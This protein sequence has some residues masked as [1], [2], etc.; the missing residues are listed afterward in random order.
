MPIEIF[1]HNTENLVKIMHT[2]NILKYEADDSHEICLEKYN[3]MLHIRHD[4]LQCLIAEQL[5]VVAHLGT[6]MTIANALGI[7]SDDPI[8][9]LTPDIVVVLSNV[10]HLIDP[11]ISV[12][13]LEHFQ[14][15]M[16]KYSKCE[17]ALKLV[18]Y[19]VKVWP[20]CVLPNL[21]NLEQYVPG[22]CNWPP[23][24]M[25]MSTFN[26]YYDMVATACKVLK[27][28]IP[29]ALF[30]M[31]DEV[32]GVAEFST[33][34][35]DPHKY[36][37]IINSTPAG[38]AALNHTYM[39]VN[40]VNE[41]FCELAQDP[42]IVEALSDHPTVSSE[43]RLAFNSIHEPPEQVGS[44]YKPTFHIPYAPNLNIHHKVFKDWEIDQVNT[45]GILKIVS[46]MSG[47]HTLKFVGHIYK[48]LK[49]ALKYQGDM[50]MF[51]T[52]FY[53]GTYLGDKSIKDRYK[54]SKGQLATRPAMI[55]SGLNLSPSRPYISRGRSLNLPAKKEGYPFFKKSGTNYTKHHPEGRI[56]GKA[57]SCP[58]DGGEH[59]AKFIDLVSQ[60]PNHIVGV[61]PI[62]GLPIGDDSPIAMALK[63]DFRAKFTDYYKIVSKTHC[64]NMV[65][66]TRIAAKAMVH[67]NGTNCK[68]D[69]LMFINTGQP[70][71]LHIM[72]G[73]GTDRAHDTGK[74]FFSIIITKDLGW[75]TP[76]F[77]EFKSYYNHTLQAHVVIYGWRR[78]SS[79]RLMFISDNYYSTLSTGFDTYTRRDQ[80]Q[81][82]TL[83]WLN[84]VYVNRALIGMCTTQRLAELLMDVR[85]LIMAACS[86]YSQAAKLIDEKFGPHYP[87]CISRWVVERLSLRVDEI[88]EQY[89]STSG[90]RKFIPTFSGN[91]R[92][93]STLGGVLNLPSLWTNERL[94]SL[95]DLFDELFIYVHTIKEP[96]S[97]YYESVK[98]INTIRKFQEAYDSLP[99]DIRHGKHTKE[100]F[101]EHI[102]SGK[103]VGCWVDVVHTSALICSEDIG[104]GCKDAIRHNVNMEPL[105]SIHS[106]KACIPE[107]ER[108]PSHSEHKKRKAFNTEQITERLKM[109]GLKPL[110][111]FKYTP[112]KFKDV[113]EYST[114]LT[115]KGNGRMKVHDCMLDHLI[116]YP[117]TRTTLDVAHWNLFENNA[118][119]E[120]HICIKAQYGSKREFYVVNWGAKCAVRMYESV[121]KSIAQQLPEEMISRPGDSKLE[122]MNDL[123]ESVLRWSNRSDDIIEFV[124]GDCSKWSACETMSSFLAMCQGLISKLG[125]PCMR[126]CQALISSWSNKLIM[127]PEVLQTGIKYITS[128]TA[129]LKSGV[130]MKST[131]NFLQGMFNYSSSTK[132]VFATRYAIKMWERVW[133]NSRPVIVKHLEHSDD[134]VLIVRVRQVADFVD[135]RIFHRLSQ[136]CH[137]II[138]SE[139][140]TNSQRYIMEFISLMSF[141]GH[142]AYPNI[143]KTKEVGCNIAAE[144]YQ[145]DI[146]AAISRSAESI[147]LGVP[148]QS[149]YIQQLLQ[150]INIYRAY[151]L[152]LGKRNE[153]P[154]SHNPYNYPLE[155][156]GLPDCLPLAY[157]GSTSDNNLYRL[158]RY[159]QPS[160]RLI[161]A[162]YNL[163]LKY[164]SEDN[165]ESD[166]EVGTT[167]FKAEYTFQKSG[168]IIKKIRKLVN[169]SSELVAEFK[170][171]CP[172]YCLLKPN[173]PQ[174]LVRWLRYMYYEP[175]FCMAYTRLSRASMA[176]RISHIVST[177]CIKVPWSDLFFDIPGFMKE[178]HSNLA[179]SSQSIDNNILFLANLTGG[180]PNTEMFFNI[181]DTGALNPMLTRP[182]YPT[183]SRLP[184]SYNFSQIHNDI[185]HIVQYMASPDR[186]KADGRQ[187]RNLTTLL[188]DTQSLQAQLG[189]NQLDRQS[190]MALFQSIKSQKRKQKFGISYS[191]VGDRSYMSYTIGY[192]THGINYTTRF[193]YTPGEVITTH[194]PYTG[195]LLF[196]RDYKKTTNMLYLVL[197][198]LTQLYF[199][200][201]VKL[202]WEQGRVRHLL[203]NSRVSGTDMKVESYLR[204]QVF[205]LDGHK[206]MFHH[207]MFSFMC[208]FLL[209]NW[210]PLDKLVMSASS[211]KHQY[212]DK[213]IHSTIKKQFDEAVYIF[214]NG[215]VALAIKN[216]GLI[217]V[218]CP[219]TGLSNLFAI[220]CI[221]ERLLLN[222]TQAS[223]ER[224]LCTDLASHVPLRASVSSFG[225]DN[226]GLR[227][228]KIGK[229]C[230]MVTDNEPNRV[231]PFVFVNSVQHRHFPLQAQLPCNAKYNYKSASIFIGHIKVFTLPLFSCGPQ[232]ILQV[233][234]EIIDD[235]IPLQILTKGDILYRYLI[236][237]LSPNTSNNVEFSNFK[238]KHKYTP[239]KSFGVPSTQDLPQLTSN[240]LSTLESI[241]G[242]TKS[243]EAATSEAS[244]RPRIAPRLMSFNFD[245]FEP[246]GDDGLEVECDTELKA[247]GKEEER[248]KFHINFNKFEMGS[249][250]SEGEE[251]FDDMFDFDEGMDGS[252]GE[253]SPDD[254]MTS[255]E[256][257][258]N[259]EAI[260]DRIEF[261]MDGWEQVV[262][263]GS[264][265]DE[266]YI[267]ESSV[268]SPESSDS[269]E[270]LFIQL[271]VNFDR[272][273]KAGVLKFMQDLPTPRVF[274]FSEWCGRNLE[275]ECMNGD[276][277][278]ELL[279]LYLRTNQVISQDLNFYSSEEIVCID[280]CTRSLYNALQSDN[281]INVVSETG[282]VRLHVK[283]NRSIGI[284][285]FMYTRQED[286][287]RRLARLRSG[288][289]QASGDRWIVTWA[290]NPWGSLMSE[291]INFK[292]WAIPGAFWNNI[293]DIS[294]ELN[295]LN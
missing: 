93:Q 180:N 158:Y 114:V 71:V 73:G 95:Q 2:I 125:L 221:S 123:S 259:I 251:E 274:M 69:S 271:D 116:R 122:P 105:S 258:I 260:R 90:F 196:E 82:I 291:P 220:Y 137:G 132:A 184:N 278:R 286:R 109:L 111:E 9:D 136:R 204:Q 78:L 59:Y 280:H 48:S 294:D 159:N 230:V 64:H 99:I 80:P 38:Q 29:S 215:V 255:R 53:T 130:K 25:L 127:V 45:L 242:F 61:D 190:I 254:G 247:K 236:G 238:Q 295:S 232:F 133:G 157:V 234:P 91:S 145:R 207:R 98:A 13:P 223:L 202:E 194:H 261:T 264:I 138:D 112:T 201:A 191:S 150:G 233:E 211:Y 23:E 176:L 164:Q 88:L 118:R 32:Q 227:L 267:E 213:N 81:H 60:A 203:N 206:D 147:R 205:D 237:K 65:Y 49:A 189:S 96:A 83:A 52:G 186:F 235:D 149:A 74:P 256:V 161:R 288:S 152:P 219:R 200:L 19:G 101:K 249:E 199:L 153:N 135:F 173:D 169:W 68:E 248:S 283:P 222:I 43:F 128:K 35:L 239:L 192:L 104:S 28:H 14:N 97:E 162:L 160:Q 89:G 151:S 292:P 253:C 5:G 229:T 20:V 166:L 100:T 124:N 272:N 27:N 181:L 208:A 21:E 51:K 287:A 246:L 58:R 265:I 250:G 107:Y 177:P 119:V 174:L 77:G 86:D 163:T 270:P 62:L 178:L 30:K 290:T 217:T 87:N 103:Q 70:N 108:I 85:Y 67:H 241:R 134:Y 172:E 252:F 41:Q 148:L 72:Q 141:N 209:N 7:V 57:L 17:H 266:D 120:A 106:T 37:D 275:K 140:K 156:F 44:R 6:S 18:G 8:L 171:Q 22:F 47:D 113:H 39:D 257:D 121:F 155:M 84:L 15:K 131:Q 284:E 188:K 110:G 46:K 36:E 66:N 102:L 126:Y 11:S 56:Y 281:L 165:P 226:L 273:M 185:R 293:L 143:K 277:L 245:N 92:L 289:F 3:G 183:V 139:K 129:Y 54:V 285:N 195:D 94:Y 26:S 262:N 24:E 55:E 146:M 198:N 175:S 187:V 168:N 228:T 79:S 216:N 76:V 1:A 4:L 263:T 224:V 214:Y 142:M 193:H 154:S 33:D 75:I 276:F 167:L 115:N 268:S 34:F 144:G 50:T 282:L 42:D 225:V 117:G 210:D 182:S 63:G 269:E 197:E 279:K 31:V 240:Q 170:E 12:N 10:V 16:L 218:L 243:L 212:Y 231:Y 179:Q 40:D 244:Q